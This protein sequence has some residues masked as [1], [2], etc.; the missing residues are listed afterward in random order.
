[1]SG[2]WVYSGYQNTGKCLD[3]TPM[4][5]DRILEG[6]LSCC[7]AAL[8]LGRQMMIFPINLLFLSAAK[9]H[10][11]NG[12]FLRLV[13][14]LCKNTAHREKE[15]PQEFLNGFLKNLLNSFL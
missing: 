12:C 15:N 8:Q 4:A 13:A 6:V 14:M 1:M 11:K 5:P 2:L 10:P 7:C 9:L 3:R